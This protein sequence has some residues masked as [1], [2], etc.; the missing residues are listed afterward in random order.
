MADS[1]GAVQ[2]A[3]TH[4]A[5]TIGA[6]GL[7]R[8]LFSQMIGKLRIRHIIDVRDLAAQQRRGSLGKEDLTTIGAAAN[9]EYH[10]ASETLGTRPDYR[11]FALTDEFAAQLTHIARLMQTG[12]V[13][14]VGAETDFRKCHRRFIAS[15]LSARYGVPVH[16]LKHE[17]PVGF[18]ST[19]DASLMWRPSTRR[20]FTI[21]F[22][23][24]GMRDFLELIRAARIKRLVDIRLRPTSQY[25]G[26]A[27]RDDLE[28]LMNLLQVEYIH[29]PE[30]APTAVLLDGYRSDGDWP[31]YER[32]FRRLLDDRRPETFL[33]QL[34][35]PGT[36]V[37]F[38]CTE[39]MPERCHRRLVAEYAKRL[40]PDL[41]VV[42]LTS[43]GVF[44]METRQSQLESGLTSEPQRAA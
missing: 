3:E 20:M 5:F 31:A 36:N 26:F 29:A 42:H 12:N 33:S 23:G 18:Q 9:A 7:S 38:L 10:D 21:G 25:S 34:L 19:L 35:T 4:A 27:R 16:H 1:R 24:K 41:K 43:K 6:S 32:E 11:L 2:S 14:I 13:L 30:L 15:F 28:Y 44:E 37:A 8:E 22:A 17:L 39:D 40:F